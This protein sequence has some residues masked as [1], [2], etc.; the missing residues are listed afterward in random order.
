ML[1]PRIYEFD[2]F[3]DDDFGFDRFFGRT[4]RSAGRRKIDTDIKETD[5][6]YE[7]EMELPGFK[8]ED[9]K[10]ELNNGYLTVTA[11]TDTSS[12]DNS[13]NGKYIRKER[14]V[15][16]YQRSFYV[17]DQLKQEDIKGSFQDGILKIEI[18][19]RNKLPKEEENKYIEI[20]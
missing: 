8:K 15:G 16:S 6:G 12:E 4:G 5:T 14:F 10:A 11:K 9:V 2:D 20:M 18:P 1:A 7:L 3:F 19:D 13:S 17:G